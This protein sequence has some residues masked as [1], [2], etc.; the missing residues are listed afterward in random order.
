MLTHVKF[1]RLKINAGFTESLNGH[2]CVKISE[3]EY[4]DSSIKEVNPPIIRADPNM[5]VWV[6]SYQVKKWWQL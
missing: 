5:K 1:K 2:L 6:D 3:K 4:H